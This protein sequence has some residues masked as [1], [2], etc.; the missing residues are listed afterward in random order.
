MKNK[1]FLQ[2]KKHQ[3]PPLRRVTGGVSGGSGLWVG[4]GS[5][6][7]GE[8]R[9]ECDVWNLGT[10]RAR[11]PAWPRTGTFGP[12]EWVDAAARKSPERRW[13]PPG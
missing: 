11:R 2:F 10:P 7:G 9:V 13:T 12:G 8:P 3:E 4:P 5:R 1:T 6:R